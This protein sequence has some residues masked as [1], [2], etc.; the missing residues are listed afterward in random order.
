M[1]T[2]A[3]YFDLMAEA[4]ISQASKKLG[5]SSLQWGEGMILEH[6][7]RGKKTIPLACI[8]GIRALQACATTEALMEDDGELMDEVLIQFGWLQASRA[9]PLTNCPVCSVHSKIPPQAVSS[10]AHVNDTHGPADRNKDPNRGGLIRVKRI[11]HQWAEQERA[12]A[13]V[14]AVASAEEVTT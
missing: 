7:R 13:G 5:M 12:A 14:V 11:L 4:D 8:Q 10:V 9:K 1:E 3:D 6:D 2:A